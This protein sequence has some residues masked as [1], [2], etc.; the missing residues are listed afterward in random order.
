M[1]VFAKQLTSCLYQ[2]TILL[3]LIGCLTPIDFPVQNAG[4]KLVVSGQISTAEGNST[5]QL[6]ETANTERKPFPVEG[7]IIR[8][9]D[10]SG[11]SYLYEEDSSRPGTYLL[12]R[13]SGVTGTTYRIQVTLPDGRVYESIAEKMPKSS[14]QYSSHHKFEEEE[15]LNDEGVASTKLFIKLFVNSTLPLDSEPL[16]I[17][18]IV[19]EAFK[20]SPTDFPDPLGRVPPT[21]YILQNSDPQ[22]IVMFS[23]FELSSKTISDLLVASREIDYSFLERHYFT[24]H[25][26]SLTREAHAY[27]RKVNILSNQVG[28]IFDTPPA[29]IKGNVYRVNNPSEKVYGY[30]QATNQTSDRFFVLPSDLPFGVLLTKCDFDG[31]YDELHYPRRCIDCISLRNSSYNRPSWF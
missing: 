29:E 26:S 1:K 12:S 30:F 27:W 15:I 24:I 13:I 17:K 21:C 18:W 11:N 9:L 6:G 7:A 25:Q 22:R 3:V 14:G 2:S 10:D 28:S 5:I 20:L 8:L 16:Y 19:D 31:S 23:S 4:G